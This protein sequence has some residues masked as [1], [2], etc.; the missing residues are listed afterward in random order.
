MTRS[1][2]RFTM[3]QQPATRWVA[4]VESLAPPDAAR[5]W[6]TEEGLLTGR[7]RQRCG[8]RTG[9]R[10]VEERDDL[11]SPAEAAV[12]GVADLSAFVREVE[13][14]CDEQAFV[15]A[16]TL[17]PVATLTAQPWLAQLGDTALGPRLASL[18]GALRDPLEFARLAP[19]ERLFERAWHGR[20]D[21]CEHLWARRARYRLGAHCLVIQEVFL[22]EALG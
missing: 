8:D 3:D 22:P 9:L 21:R 13:L 10:I 17:V 15:F 20:T 16:Q 7:V 2:P 12:L 6:L 1:S 4:R 5:A 11:L 18:G 14:T 19:G